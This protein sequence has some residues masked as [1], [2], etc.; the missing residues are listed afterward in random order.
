M[1]ITGNQTLGLFVD[2]QEKLLPHITHH[3]E[4]LENTLK[5]IAGLKVLNIP[6]LITQQYTKGL[7][8]TVDP[9]MSCVENFSYSEKN[10]FSCC[11]DPV[12]YKKLTSQGKKYIVIAG[13][14]THVCVLQTVIDLI[15]NEF[16]PIVVEDCTGSRK[17]N[18]KKIA[19]KR[20]KQSGAIVTTCES[21]LFEITRYAGTPVFKAISKIIK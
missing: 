17:Q 1:R 21:I 7:G 15:E 11:D 14:E 6:L 9:V 19:L 4:I 5:L 16:V 13:I 18:D 3:E 8:N 12:F 10:S 20:I 2:F